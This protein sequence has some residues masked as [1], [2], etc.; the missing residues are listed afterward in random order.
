[1]KNDDVIVIGDKV[2]LV[3]DEDHIYKTMI[4]DM[5]GNGFFLAGIPRSGGMPVRLQEGDA[6]LL[7]FSRDSG[8]Y[9]ISV[10]ISGFE[11]RGDIR[12]VW[13]QQ[14]S[15][16]QIYQ[17]RGA[18]RLPV[19]MKVLVYEYEEEF[20]KK[21]LTQGDII[22]NEALE[23]VESKDI[24]TSGIALVVKR[25]YELS[26]KLLLKPSMSEMQLPQPPLIVRAE[27]V[28]LVPE[29][30]RGRNCVGTQ[31]FGQ[32]ESMTEYISKYVLTEQQKQI[33]QLRLLG[34]D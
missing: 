2:E 21:L 25:K 5:T 3:K 10:S 8:K 12:Y 17:R 29:R 33:R 18:Y 14:T 32:T 28:R 15:K 7:L 30:Y 16:P 1:M 4:E 22:E 27:V 9:S 24:S 31:F 20:E 6:L 23:V 34:K 26:D 19:N 13:F 11:K